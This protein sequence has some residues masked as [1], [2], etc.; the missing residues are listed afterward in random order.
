MNV[1]LISTYD[2]GRQP[3]GLASAAAELRARGHEVACAD[4]SRA[5]L[6]PEAVARAGAVGF[7]IPM[8]TATRLALA[9]LP[10]VRKHNPAALIAFFGLYAPM[11]ADL[12]VESGASAVIGGEFEGPLCDAVDRWAAGAFSSPSVVSSLERRQFRLPDRSGLPPLD[13]YAALITPAAT[14]FTPGDRDPLLGAEPGDGVTRTRR[15]SER[16]EAGLTPGETSAS[17][18]VGYTEASRGCKHLCRHCPVVPVYNG[19][20]R[21]VQ[22]EIV[23][24]DIEQQ[25]AAGASHITF[26]DPD[27]FNGPGHALAIV[28]ELHRRWPAVTWD[29]TIKV[30]HLLRQADKLS[31]LRTS[32]CAL[33]TTA[34]ESFDDTLL[35]LLEKGH[36]RADFINVLRLVRAAGIPLSP[37][38]VPFTPWTTLA[39]Y[40][41]LLDTIEELDLVSSVA[42]VQLA[43]RLLV[44]RGSRL[45]ELPEMLSA[46]RDAQGR[47]A[48]IQASAPPGAGA[49]VEAAVSIEA[50]FDSAALSYRWRSDDEG[51]ERLQLA[52][53]RAVADAA[54][55][56]QSR[57]V[58]F[59]R[60]HR[61]SRE[62]A[63][64][65]M[66]ICPTVLEPRAGRAAVPY[67]NEPWFC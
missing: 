61:L 2:L 66:P 55:R 65:P 49:P 54:E 15:L 9:L 21:I 64:L 32:G 34:V 3:F 43:V 57:E 46:L 31:L 51:V 25:I 40:N 18:T 62:A 24:A 17:K 58:T 44:P 59:S 36:T 5:A 42:P 8:H 30:E 48:P 35:A 39:A 4:V 23:L 38:F 45:L 6:D 19:S 12:L 14:E 10:A 11:N 28:A 37:T 60:L 20:F 41:E 7:F 53:Q 16:E 50:C 29:A 22:R 56:G 26:G 27:F 33:I 47:P 1:V 67:L 63:G 52:V 13:T